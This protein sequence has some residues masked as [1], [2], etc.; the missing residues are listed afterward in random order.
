MENNNF[1]RQINSGQPFQYNIENYEDKR[2]H[3]F[4]GASLIMGILSFIVCIPVIPGLLG[5]IFGAV[6]LSQGNREGMTIAGI[7]TSSIG[8]VVNAALTV[9]IVLLS[10]NA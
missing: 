8:F 7:I 5:I 6:S 4:G 10:I 9:F 2:G 1:N 3:N